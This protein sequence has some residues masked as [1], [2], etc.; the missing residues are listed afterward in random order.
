MTYAE[1]VESVAKES[2]QSKAAV[3]ELLKS[4]FDTIKN[5]ALDG[6]AVMIPGF[7]RFVKKDIKSRRIPNGKMSE[8]R[9]TIKLRPFV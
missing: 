7:G 3:T 5:K 9:T 2:G 6:N 1:L 8:P 4:T